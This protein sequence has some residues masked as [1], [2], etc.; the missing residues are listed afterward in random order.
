MSAPSTMDN[1]FSVGNLNKFRVRLLYNQG[2][3]SGILFG[4][5]DMI[6]QKKT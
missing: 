6:S 1:C 5:A 3:R 2:L 4:G